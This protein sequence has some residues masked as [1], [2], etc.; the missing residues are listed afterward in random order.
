MVDKRKALA[1]QLLEGTPTRKDAEERVIDFFESLGLFEREGYLSLDMVDCSFGHWVP[2][3]WIACKEYI[4]KEY[5]ALPKGGSYYE[6]FENLANRLD[7]KS[8][9][10]ILALSLK[11]DEI[12]KFLKE[13]RDL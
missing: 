13:E 2:R 9:E 10:N 1:K 8:N 7:K 5:R 6:E 4:Q 11:D 3:W 12:Q